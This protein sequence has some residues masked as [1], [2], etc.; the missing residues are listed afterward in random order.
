MVYSTTW[1]RLIRDGD[2]GGYFAFR[3]ILFV[4]LG[5]VA[6]WVVYRLDRPALMAL[7]VFG[8]AASV[9]GLLAVLTPLGTTI[10]GTRAWLTLP[11]GFTLQPAEFAKVFVVLLAALWLSDRRGMRGLDDPP[12]PQAVVGVLAA[13]GVVAGLLLL[14]PD[15]GS[16]LVTG[17][18]VLG[19]LFVAGVR[20]R[21]LVALLVAGALGAIGAYAVGVLDAY[22]V[23]RFTA[24][25]DPAA[26]PQ[27]VGYNVQQALIAI[28]TGGVQGQGLLAGAHT[29]GAFV[30]Y[31]YTDFIFSAVGE[32]LG[33]LGG[34]LVI[35]GF[36]VLLLRGVSAAQRAD[37]FGA[38]VA[39]GIVCWLAA[40]GFENLGMNVGLLP[41]TGVPLPFV[42]YGGS[43]VIAAW[44][45]V[46]LLLRVSRH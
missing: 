11:G 15:L 6:A 17:A 18:A 4:I 3:Q 9:A 43:S 19:V 39:T 31:Q 5:A 42:S 40:Q 24:F 14:Q 25:L 28:G 36:L 23:A 1:V 35:T 21:L 22:Q 33:M 46:G 29:Q 7:A 44:I 10:N 30:P 12:E 8:Y 34:L 32:E 45:G 27:G 20:G 41:V 16:A 2:P 37:R 38:L 26:D 13:T